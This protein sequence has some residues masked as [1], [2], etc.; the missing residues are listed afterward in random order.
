MSGT[1]IQ[2]KYSGTSGSA[3]PSSG[4]LTQAELAYSFN[5]DKLFIG[6]GDTPSLSQVI[7]GKLFVD[8]LDHSAGTLTASS[9]ILVD[10]NKKIDILNIDN[11][12]IDSNTI[13]TTNS[14]GD[15]TLNP[16]GSGK[17]VLSAATDIS[18]ILTVGSNTNITGILTVTGSVDV[19]NIN[20][21]GNQIATS[22]T[23]GDLT[24]AT[25][26]L[27]KVVLDGT[28]VVVLPKGTDSNRPTA[29]SST[30]GALRYSTQHHR[31]EGVANGGWLT[32]G[33]VQDTDKD[34]YITA[35]QSSD[36]DTLRF[37]VAGTEKVKLDSTGF[38]I[39]DHLEVDGTANIDGNTTIG[40]NLTVTGNTV[41][42]GD[43][44]VN[45]TTTTVNT[46]VTT[47][48]DPVIH[49]GEGSLAA[50]DSNDRGV[51]FEWG[52]GSAV[53][54]GF[55]GLDMGTGRFSF[56]KVLGTGDTTPDDNQFT[57]PWGDAQ[58]A[59][60]YLSANQTVSG[61]STVTGNSTFGGTLGVTGATTLSDVLTVTGVTTLNSTLSVSGATTIGGALSA[62]A[63]IN[64]TSGD[65][66]IAPAGGDTNITGTLAV[67]GALSAASLSLTGGA[68]PV[69]SG[70]TGMQSFTG[71]G[72]FVSNAAGTA[73]SFI[74][75]TQ[76]QI[77][78][79]NASGVP[80]ASST[81]DGG[82][83]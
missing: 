52:D 11:I 7:G 4:T 82:T 66:T 80:V 62:D 15:L 34:T 81:I 5:S 29:S 24:L 63:G 35:E 30:D 74:T 57:S 18:G 36:D 17:V 49:V 67:S 54:N 13:S 27:G 41:V 1:I 55:F 50:G 69:A 14:N 58:F 25:N 23:N 43:L 42:S 2:I 46:T 71:S 32:I 45:G 40:A 26:G 70:G 10:S 51:S 61:T 77:L 39:D 72:F 28:T 60:L 33:G 22:N 56:Q 68:L 59:S 16:N 21:N 31:F 83:F 53:Q 44:T 3:A 37:Y 76:Y 79:F 75:G 48:T 38:Q 19:D 20:I 9:A 65:L 64:T 8:M 6:N 12:T 73:M 47:L 78:Q